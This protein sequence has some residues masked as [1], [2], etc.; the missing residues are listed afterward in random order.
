ML[1]IEVNAENYKTILGLLKRAII[2]NG[3]GFDAKDE[4]LAGNPNQMNIMSAYADI[5]LDADEMESEFSASM[6]ELLWFVNAYLHI[7]KNVEPKDVNFIFNRDMMVN[8][9]EQIANAKNSVGILSD[10]T[11]VANHPWTKDV[12]DEMARIKKEREENMAQFDPY[13]KGAEDE[14]KDE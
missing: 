13:G 9:S 7:A 6:H 5:D 1:H 2:E 10:E 4:R 8:T 3:R 11:I 12:K 14:G